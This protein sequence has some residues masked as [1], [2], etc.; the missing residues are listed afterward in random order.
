MTIKDIARECNV[1]VSTVSRVLN[2]RPDVSAAVREKVLKAVEESGYIPNASAR[3][4]VRTDSNT[5]GVIV[6]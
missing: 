6:R 4:L 3:D 1:A 2:N 5:I